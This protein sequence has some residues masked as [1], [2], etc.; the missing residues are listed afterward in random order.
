MNVIIPLFGAN[1]LSKNFTN[2]YSPHPICFKQTVNPPTVKIIIF[3]SKIYNSSFTVN[4]TM[5]IGIQS[6]INVFLSVKFCIILTKLFDYN[7]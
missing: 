2:S 1:S 6:K 3:C 7:F 4:C 5:N